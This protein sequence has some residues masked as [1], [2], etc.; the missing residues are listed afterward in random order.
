MCI[1]ILHIHINMF[2]YI[3]TYRFFRFEMVSQVNRCVG[4][5]WAGLGWAGLGY[6]G[7]RRPIGC[8]IVIGHFPQKS[9]IIIAFFAEEDLQLKASYASSP[10]CIM[11]GAKHICTCCT[12]MTQVYTQRTFFSRTNVMPNSFLNRPSSLLR[13]PKPAPL[14]CD[15]PICNRKKGASHH[16]YNLLHLGYHFPNLKT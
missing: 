2:I 10:H 12:M 3:Y 1:H 5:G 16:M 15:T 13:S 9:L 7:R 8:L 6:H 14:S 11:V 4:S